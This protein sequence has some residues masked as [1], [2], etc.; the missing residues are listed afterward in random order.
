MILIKTYPIKLLDIASSVEAIPF[1]QVKN[2]K[3]LGQ[4][5]PGSK[6][7]PAVGLSQ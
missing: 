4:G 6:S 2:P 1:L 7:V 3:G 5:K